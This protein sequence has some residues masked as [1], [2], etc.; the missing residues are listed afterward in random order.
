[1]LLLDAV[2]NDDAAPDGHRRLSGGNKKFLFIFLFLINL[3][4]LSFTKQ[5]RKPN[6]NW[7]AK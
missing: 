4:M 1:M 6:L 5:T 3:N 7:V 2:V